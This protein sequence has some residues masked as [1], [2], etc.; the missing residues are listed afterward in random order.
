MNN[1]GD[2]RSI[3]GPLLSPTGAARQQSLR[4]HNLALV[5]RAV[6]EA[7]GPLT[8]ARIAGALGLTRATVSDLVDRLIAARLVD[9]LEP[10][11]VGRAGRPGMLLAPHRGGVAGL[12]LEIQVDH[13]AVRVTTLDGSSL[14]EAREAGDH[15]AS[16]PAVVARRLGRLAAQVITQ[17]P[18]EIELAGACVSVPA[19]LRSGSG[20]VA[21][22]PNLGWSGIDLIPLLAQHPDLGALPIELGNDADLSARAE[23][24]ARAVAGGMARVEQSFLYIAGEVGIGGAIVVDGEPARGQHGWSGEI[25]HTV[26]DRSGPRCACGATGCLEQYAGL[27]VIRRRSG[28]SVETTAD[29]LLDR[30]RRSIRVRRSLQW[31]SSAIGVAVATTL[32]LVDV[33]R[34]VLG[35]VYAR[36]FDHLA[37]GIEREVRAR[38]LAARW[39]PVE[40]VAALAGPDSAAKGAGWRVLDGV[41]ADPARWI[42][43]HSH[44]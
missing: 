21:L 42:A 19:L 15:R 23:T 8:R 44:P 27:D 31:A 43:D 24:R 10:E 1:R 36:L 38:V 6:V 11:L 4:T 40:V 5:L 30:A 20:I 3:G 34:V 17:L 22:A 2:G 37:P 41:V 25:G 13:L 9:E 39:T 26:I 35:G 33:E 16:D 12:G 14:G 29:Q 32:N 7:P 18:L 28:L